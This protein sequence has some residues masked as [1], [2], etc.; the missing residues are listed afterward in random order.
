[1]LKE[2][3]IY[4]KEQ[5]IKIKNLNPTLDYFIDN[6]D[7]DA[8]FKLLTEGI[9]INNDVIILSFYPGY[10]FQCSNDNKNQIGKMPICNIMEK[11]LN[12]K[13]YMLNS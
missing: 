9:R 13:L 10:G 7:D 12:K 4:L 2:C 5:N 6:F 3:L 1:M 11:L 8:L